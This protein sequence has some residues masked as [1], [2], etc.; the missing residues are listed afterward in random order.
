MCTRGCWGGGGWGL[1]N[2]VNSAGKKIKCVPKWLGQNQVWNFTR[3][4]SQTFIKSENYWSIFIYSNYAKMSSLHISL[5]KV[6]L[7]TYQ[8]GLHF[9]GFS[10]RRNFSHIFAGFAALSLRC[11]WFVSRM[12]V[13]TQ[14]THWYTHRVGSANRRKNTHTHPRTYANTILVSKLSA[15]K[16]I[17]RNFILWEEQSATCSNIWGEILQSVCWKMRQLHLE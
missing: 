13:C 16:K 1:R 3:N 9:S 5:Q 7:G 4:V 2:T 12:V 15:I 14:T 10:S 6:V 11:S 17:E 8:A